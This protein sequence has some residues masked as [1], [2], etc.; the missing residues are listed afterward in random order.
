M[1]QRA[2][3]ALVA[4]VLFAGTTLADIPGPGRRPRRPPEPVRP[5]PLVTANKVSVPV[6]V[7]NA[8]L[9]KDGKAVKAKIAI[10]RKLLAKIVPGVA[11]GAPVDRQSSMPWWS[12]VIAG[13]AMSAGA[14]G[15]VFVARG[16]KTARVVSTACVVIAALTAGYALADIRVPTEEELRPAGGDSIV[17]EVVD[18]GDA[19][20]LTLPP[21]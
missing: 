4:L 14:V 15:L 1:S 12:T 11:A 8:D 9:R 18:D 16:N 10:P 2:V 3:M 19:V 5:D 13:I 17:I 6:E 21:L 20:V 7:K